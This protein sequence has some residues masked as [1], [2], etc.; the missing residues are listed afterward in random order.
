MAELQDDDLAVLINVERRRSRVLE[1]LP[2]TVECIHPDDESGI[3]WFVE[4]I[5]AMYSNKHRLTMRKPPSQ[6]QISKDVDNFVNKMKWRWIFRESE[7]EQVTKIRRETPVC[8][9]LVDMEVTAWARML[10]QALMRAAD[11]VKSGDF[12]TPRLYIWAL[13]RL[14]QSE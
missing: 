10:R 13:R 4:W 3:P 11:S 6:T 7:K 12:N 14:K 1:Y 8:E 2:E 5:G 9:K